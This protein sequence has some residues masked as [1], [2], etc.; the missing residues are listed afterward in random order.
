MSSKR[1]LRVQDMLDLTENPQ[2]VSH[3]SEAPEQRQYSPA[4]AVAPQ[5]EA[6]AED[7]RGGVD[8][9]HHFRGSRYPSLDDNTVQNAVEV[10][11]PLSSGHNSVDLLEPLTNTSQ[12]FQI[13][14]PM[15]SGVYNSPTRTP[16]H[17]QSPYPFLHNDSGHNVQQVP[18]SG[19]QRTQYLVEDGQFPAEFGPV[20]PGSGVGAGAIDGNQATVGP[21]PAGYPSAGVGAGAPQHD[22]AVGV[23]QPGAGA[24]AFLALGRSQHHRPS[25]AKSQVHTRY[26]AGT[27]LSHTP[28]RIPLGEG[29]G[30]DLMALFGDDTEPR[31]K[32]PLVVERARVGKSVYAGYPAGDTVLPAHL[33]LEQIASQYANHVWGQMLRVFVAEGWD[34]PRIYKA[35]PLDARA[36]RQKGRPWNFLQHGIGREQDHIYLEVTGRKR[37]PRKKA[38]AEAEEDEEGKGEGQGE[39]QGKGQGGVDREPQAGAEAVSEVA[40][41]ETMEQ[42]HRRLDAASTQVFDQICRNF[43]ADLGF[44][45]RSREEQVMTVEA[46][47]LQE[48]WARCDL[49]RQLWNM[50]AS[51]DA[52]YDGN[53]F[54][55]YRDHLLQAEVFRPRESA[56][57]FGDRMNLQAM[58]MTANDMEAM[59]AGR[60]AADVAG[61]RISGLLVG[62]LPGVAQGADM[63]GQP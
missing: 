47:M 35:L 26:P 10:P 32:W 38:E 22:T 60:D 40:S 62:A 42:A 51:G 44:R 58:I 36:K 56:E 30:S 31:T 17:Q 18:Y 24:G 63:Y 29:S 37:K 19:G 16:H 12:G 6:A 2:L 25:I 45:G 50:A 33:T 41:L 9:G 20:A 1:V 61:A 52:T 34:A 11:R 39:G 23:V 4:W 48:I 15:S 55:V 3:I 28:H 49:L 57:Q 13:D 59:A 27:V 8:N 14:L 46:S 5:Y 54:H 21:G 7:N 53:L 43:F